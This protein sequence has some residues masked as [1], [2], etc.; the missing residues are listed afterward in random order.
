MFL[1]V[2]AMATALS[3]CDITTESIDTDSNN[4][5]VTS[6]ESG[7]E[8]NKEETASKRAEQERL[9]SEQE[10]AASEQEGAASEQNSVPRRLRV[11]I[12]K[13]IARHQPPSRF[14]GLRRTARPVHNRRRNCGKALVFQHFYN[15]VLLAGTAEEAIS[16][17]HCCVLSVSCSACWRA[18]SAYRAKPVLPCASPALL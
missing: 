10:G 9:A 14:F 8:S 11:R 4:A 15:R 17:Y 12:K 2:L 6:A 18:A 13:N 16:V 5:I 3:G 7:S 1:L